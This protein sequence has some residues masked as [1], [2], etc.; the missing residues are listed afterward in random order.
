MTNLFKRKIVLI[1][2]IAVLLIVYILQLVFEN[3]DKTRVIRTKKEIDCIK[4]FNNDEEKLWVQKKG[5]EWFLGDSDSQI[6]AFKAVAFVNSLEE[7]KILDAVSKKTDDSER[8]GLDKV[9]A[10]KIEAYSSGKK[11]RTVL[12]GKKSSTGN[13]EYV[14]ID[15]EKEICL[16]QG[17]FRSVFEV[18]AESIKVKKEESLV[19]ETQS[20]EIPSVK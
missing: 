15:D 8:Y 13:Q 19:P 10:L 16:S 6:Q 11:I 5:D 18:D 17:S 7:I 9:S 1:S 20:A 12:A 14:I 3:T 4:V 2:A